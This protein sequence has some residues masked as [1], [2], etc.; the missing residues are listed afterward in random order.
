MTNT[1]RIYIAVT[2]NIKKY[3]IEH[4]IKALQVYITQNNNG[5]FTR[6]NDARKI[7]SEVS[8][9]QVMADILITT[10]KYDVIEEQ[11]E[12]AKTLPNEQKVMNAIYDY[13][14][15]NKVSVQLNF[16][17]LNDLIKKMINNLDDVLNLL[18]DNPDVFSDYLSSYIVT[19]SNHR[20]D[21]NAISNDNYSQINNYFDQ[22]EKVNAHQK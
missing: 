13:N 6:E 20:R 10:L 15:G 17:E 5:Y 3:G 21:L 8:P 7:I 12:Y 4:A 2:E 18:A 16:V 11:K 14:Q 1:D 19:I 9:F 22:F